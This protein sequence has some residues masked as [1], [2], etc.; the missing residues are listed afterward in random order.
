MPRRVGM[1]GTSRILSLGIEVREVDIPQGLLSDAED[2]MRYP[3]GGSTRGWNE[4]KR[5]EVNAEGD[6]RQSENPEN[7][8]HLLTGMDR[9]A[10][11]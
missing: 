6:K 9:T 10:K 5:S 1:Q 8:L 7:G 11:P 4:G 2:P 3:H